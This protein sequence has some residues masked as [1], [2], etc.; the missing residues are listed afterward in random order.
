MLHVDGGRTFAFPNAG[1]NAR[2]AI[3]CE[4]VIKLL[5]L[6]GLLTLWQAVAVVISGADT[7]LKVAA[8]RLHTH[9]RSNGLR[10]ARQGSDEVSHSL[11]ASPR[12]LSNRRAPHL[13]VE[14]SRPPFF[15][16][17]A[18]DVL[19]VSPARIAL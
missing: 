15:R 12:L 11:C 18:A 1:L 4:V 14:R 19:R 13:T 3:C 7:P 8:F 5:P 9:S 17:G 6:L 16:D 10:T 2:G